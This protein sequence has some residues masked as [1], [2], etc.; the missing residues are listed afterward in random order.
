M[1]RAAAIIAVAGLCLTL[2][3][4]DTAAMSGSRQIRP[5]RQ[6]SVL[7]AD[8]AYFKS[9]TDP[10]RVRLEIYYQVRHG[11]LEFRKEGD[12]FV[13]EYEVTA[14]VLDKKNKVV[15][16]ESHPRTVT[17]PTLERTTSRRDF[18]TSQFAF[19]LD[20]G[21]YWVE[22]VLSDRYRDDE[23][24][25]QFGV[26]LKPFKKDRPYLS[27][28][29]FVYSVQAGQETPG[30][31]DKAGY[32]VVPSVV[33]TYGGADSAS[34]MYYHE[35]YQGKDSNETV[36]LETRLRH[37]TKGM[38]YRDT[39]YV[40]LD[41]PV[42]RQLRRI[43]LDQL[44]A[45]SYELEIW[46]RGRRNKKLQVMREPFLVLWSPDQLVQHDWETAVAQLAYIA[47]ASELKPIRE[48]KNDQERQAAFNAFWDA[49]D[50]TRGTPENEAKWEFYRRINYVNTRFPGIRREG[51]RT[52]RGRI[53][54]QYGPPDEIDDI[55]Y[56]PNAPPYQVWHYFTRGEYLRF[57]FV[58]ENQ[59]GD[60]RLQF[61]YDGRGQRP[62][63]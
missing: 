6:L 15:A 33:R 24:R 3:S 10:S 11:G 45:G 51:W 39:L 54:I 42:K 38:V 44:P 56:A 43:S 5:A 49:R 35:I 20:P 28:L 40:Q 50:P 52:D 59:D 9:D 37:W 8:W 27:G 2:V 60:Y 57:V 17:V 26:N 14:T 41:T 55:P 46:L 47:D 23:T 7:D 62:D 22:L 63:F 25:R 21:R 61:P 29:E 13:A 53:Y 36:L 58:D 18:R 19:Y 34:L 4:T 32:D 31:F 16:Q 48:A 30:V 1:Y 12:R